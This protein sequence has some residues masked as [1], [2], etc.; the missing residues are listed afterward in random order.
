MLTED[1]DLVVRIRPDVKI[2]RVKEHMITEARFP[3]Q[4]TFEDY[5]S[6]KNNKDESLDKILLHWHTTH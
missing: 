6:I 3:K 1:Y 4:S 5:I 2:D